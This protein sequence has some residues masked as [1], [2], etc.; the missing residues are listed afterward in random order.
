MQRKGSQ[1]LISAL[2]IIFCLTGGNAMAQNNTSTILNS[3]SQQEIQ[4]NLHR[5]KSAQQR[6]A[7]NQHRRNHSFTDFGQAYTDFK[8]RLNKEYN[9]DYSV[10]VSYMAQRA[11]PSGKK[12][13]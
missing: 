8:N 10:D 4:K 12:T 7:A 6:V 2:T 11:T 13:S 1:Y 9:F 5:S 3:A